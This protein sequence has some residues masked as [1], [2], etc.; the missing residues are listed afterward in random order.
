MISI[1]IPGEARGKGRPRFARRGKFVATYTDEKTANY[2][3]LV[4]WAGA[5]AMKGRAPLGCAVNVSLCVHT[6]PPAS[7]S[8][9]KQ[10]LALAGEIF[11]TTKPD[12]DN[13]QKILY[14]ALNGIVW[15]DDK[16]IVTVAFKKRYAEIPGVVLDVVEAE[17]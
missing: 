6:A 2:E 11:P 13:I 8:K 10:S 14:D 7:W 4:A 9:K 15:V 1:I 16:Q 5:Q 17:A 12:A 3:N